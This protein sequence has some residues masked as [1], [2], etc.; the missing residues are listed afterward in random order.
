VV[1]KIAGTVEPLQTVPLLL[2]LGRRSNRKLPVELPHLLAA[3]LLSFLSR[4]F[5]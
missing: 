2:K 1:R 3:L 5:F 4:L